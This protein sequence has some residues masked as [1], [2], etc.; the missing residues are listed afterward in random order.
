MEVLRALAATIGKMFATDLWLTATALAAVGLAAAG[1]RGHFIAPAAA[2]F[3]L[4]A[5]VLIALAVGVI[6]GARR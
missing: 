6:R 4:A 5:G 2:P 1:L 3:V